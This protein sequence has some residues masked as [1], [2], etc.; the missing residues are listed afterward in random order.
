MDDEN[1]T[2]V[3]RAFL[4]ACGRMS[5]LGPN[6]ALNVLAAVQ[7]KRKSQ[8]KIANLHKRIFLVVNLAYFVV[9]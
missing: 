1:Y 5:V 4:Q 9:V 2:N 8:K 3:H 6:Q 7:A